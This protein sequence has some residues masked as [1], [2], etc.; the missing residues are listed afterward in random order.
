MNCFKLFH[1][2]GSKIYCF[3]FFVFC[4]VFCL[5]ADYFVGHNKPQRQI[6]QSQAISRTKQE[7]LYELLGKQREQWRFAFCQIDH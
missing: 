6:T 4:F 5:W 7:E 2:H 3:C 1:K